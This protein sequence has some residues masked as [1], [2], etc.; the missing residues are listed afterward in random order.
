M[1]LKSPKLKLKHFYDHKYAIEKDDVIL[2]K[3]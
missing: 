1:T 3:E 2:T